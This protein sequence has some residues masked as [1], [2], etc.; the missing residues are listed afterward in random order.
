M[1]TDTVEDVEEIDDIEIAESA[2]EPASVPRRSAPVRR[3]PAER[4]RWVR[5][6][7]AV[8]IAGLIGATGFFG[9]RY[10][11]GDDAPS[12]ASSS[13]AAVL[14]VANDY[15]VKLSSFDYRDLDKNRTAI[16]AMSTAD[17]GKK[18]DE[19]VKALTEI[20]ANGKGEA[21]AE[22]SHSAVESLKGDQAT[23]LL[24]V[25]QTA[26]NVVAPEGRSQPYRMVVK[27]K[28]V[29]GRW[30]VDDVETV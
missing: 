20:V 15:A 27:L 13:Q 19:M 30:L 8:L 10:F 1:A 18:Y 25:D 22:V 5:W 14:G 21:T 29:D 9:Y 28:K 3:S 16:A 12:T 26:K 4:P 11:A 24:F 7:V 2:A 23:V 17:F 6:A